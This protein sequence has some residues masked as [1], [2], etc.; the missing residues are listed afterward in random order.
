[1][2]AMEERKTQKS[3]QLAPDRGMILLVATLGGFLVT[4]MA[5]S[6]NI[7][8]PLIGEEFQASAV[9]LSWISMSMILVSGAI[10]LPIGRL[11]DTY[12]RVRFFIFSMVL[13]TV[14]LFASAFAPSAWVL[15]GMRALT[16][17]SLA[18]GSVTSTALV[19]PAYPPE[20]RGRALGL[21]IGGVYL[22][23]TVG[24]I[25]GGFIVHNLGWRALFL[26]VGAAALVDVVL[27]VWKLRHLEWREPKKAPFDLA[28]SI[29]YAVSLTMLLLGFSWLPGTGGLV[30]VPLSLAGLAGFLWWET[31]AADPLLPVSLLRKNRVFAFTNGAVLVNYAATSAMIF[32]M[33]LYLQYNRGLN[34]QTAGLV[35]VAGT[36]FQ[37]VMS[38]VA[39]RLSD[40]VPA[41]YVATA[42]MGLCVV[43]LFALVFLGEATPYWYIILALIVLGFGFALFS[44]P[45]THVVMGSVDNRLLGVASATIAAVRQAGMS[46]ST[47]VAA[48]VLAVLVGRKVITAADYPALLTSIRVTFLIFTV[49]CAIGI[50]MSLVGPGKRD[51]AAA[52]D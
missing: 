39:G 51:R 16:G 11:A 22:G 31:K 50:G 7:A 19:I 44:T 45:A 9:M 52:E 33:S 14:A 32:L 42:G 1:M 38:P 10:L 20:S 2:E 48:L 49:L 8:L 36:F 6:V 23:L 27:P 34:A 25:L 3:R 29:I 15:L 13:F 40:R 46:L 24:P 4:F 26:I 28:G 18:I 17:V 47:G 43:G 12:G 21:N 5:S 37:A 41:H 35:L 30:L